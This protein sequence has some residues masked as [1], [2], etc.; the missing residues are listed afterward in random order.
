MPNHQDADRPQ[1]A[2]NLQADLIHPMAEDDRHSDLLIIDLGR[3]RRRAPG[4]AQAALEAR[5]EEHCTAMNSQDLAH[6]PEAAIA[7]T[8]TKE[9][10][11]S[12]TKAIAPSK[13]NVPTPM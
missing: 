6:A 11:T 5:L 12:S 9:L 2:L 8:R 1:D 7:N 13:T 4:E 3:Q 10:A